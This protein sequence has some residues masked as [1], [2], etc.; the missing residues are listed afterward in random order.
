MTYAVLWLV[1]P[2]AMEGPLSSVRC[3]FSC[4]E[5]VRE[6]LIIASEDY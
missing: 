6:N 4:S 2:N 5:G 3:R 1:R